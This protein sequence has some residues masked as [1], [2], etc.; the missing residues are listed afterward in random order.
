M[1]EK[2]P[3]GRPARP[4]TEKTPAWARRLRQLREA[5]GWSI[6]DLAGEA[7]L[8]E[9]SVARYDS[10]GRDPSVFAALALAHAL[11]TTVEGL[12]GNGQ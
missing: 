12:F 2:Q 5:R 8:D 9:A 10:G 1:S 7:G 11:G 6:R 3:M 4:H